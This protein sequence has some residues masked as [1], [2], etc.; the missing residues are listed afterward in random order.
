MS[1]AI[2]GRGRKRN[3]C[4]TPADTKCAKYIAETSAKDKRRV[5]PV[6][7]L[8]WT[9]HSIGA[10]EHPYYGD[11]P[12]CS[13]N[14]G[15]RAAALI[16]ACAVTQRLGLTDLGLLCKVC[17]GAW[18]LPSENEPICKPIWRARTPAYIVEGSGQLLGAIGGMRL[19][20]AEA[21][22]R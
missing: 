3:I 10:R 5:V 17:Q 22:A 18:A 21:L 12:A 9:Q 16:N 15:W 4:G 2:R 20:D 7:A 1:H 19:G 8:G 14:M 11:D 13:G 6:R